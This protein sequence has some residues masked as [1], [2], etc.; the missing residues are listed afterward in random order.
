MNPGSDIVKANLR[1]T[2]FMIERYKFSSIASEII[3]FRW[4]ANIE[5]ER[6]ASLTLKL[7]YSYIFYYRKEMNSGILR[8]F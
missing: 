1:L 3:Q 7:T 6:R 8:E 2:S 5:Q 4:D